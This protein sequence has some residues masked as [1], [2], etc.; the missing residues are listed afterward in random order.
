MVA[1]RSGLSDRSSDCPFPFPFE[2]M[3]SVPANTD[4]AAA[5]AASQE[6]VSPVKIPVEP[7]HMEAAQEKRTFDVAIGTPPPQKGARRYIR[8]DTPKREHS[9][10]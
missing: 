3:A 7:P 2:A 1:E 6:R 4:D 10:A 9:K 5:A 8:A